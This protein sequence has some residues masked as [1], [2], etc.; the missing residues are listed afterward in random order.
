MLLAARLFLTPKPHLWPGTFRLECLA[1]CTPVGPPQH[2]FG[3][4]LKHCF[5][6][7]FRHLMALP[8][9]LPFRDVKSGNSIQCCSQDVKHQASRVEAEESRMH[10]QH[11]P[12]ATSGSHR[13][14][15]TN[16]AFS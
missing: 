11:S 4:L 6:Q 15:A 10:P 8:Q 1:L 9:C 12:K 14:S 5:C 16:V 2:L 13:P 3:L 7:K